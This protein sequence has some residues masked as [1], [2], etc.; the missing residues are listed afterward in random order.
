MS[1]INGFNTGPGDLYA[2]RSREHQ[3]ALILVAD[4]LETFFG[5][6]HGWAQNPRD[7]GKKWKPDMARAFLDLGRQ[8]D[9]LRHYKRQTTQESEV[10]CG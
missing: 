7:V 4:A 1:D 6:A 8:L 2:V 10:T 9:T 3:V 5:F